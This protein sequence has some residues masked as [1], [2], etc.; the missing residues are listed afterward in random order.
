MMH[1]MHLYANVA[2]LQRGF[3]VPPLIRG[4]EDASQRTSSISERKWTLRLE[5]KNGRELKI[6]QDMVIPQL[7]NEEHIS[8]HVLFLE[9]QV[10]SLATRSQRRRDLS[11]EQIMLDDRRPIATERLHGYSSQIHTLFAAPNRSLL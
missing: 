11:T 3:G 2:L 8:T 4:Y 6:Q 1:K 7:A 9:H 10:D 5:R